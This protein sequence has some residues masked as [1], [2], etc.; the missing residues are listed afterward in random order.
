[1]LSKLRRRYGGIKSGAVVALALGILIGGVPAVAQ[2]VATTSA[3]LAKSVAQALKLSGAA[4]KRS[5]KALSI[6]KG[7][8]KQAGPQGIPG[9]QGLQGPKGDDG[10]QG[11][12]GVSGLQV[13]SGQTVED[14]SG[15]KSLTVECPAGKRVFGGGAAAKSTQGPI[16][17]AVTLSAS[18]PFVDDVNQVLPSE[19]HW[20][21]EAQEQTASGAPWHLNV[22]AICGNA[23]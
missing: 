21:A 4:S 16:A 17:G 7:V 1:M 6:A 20:R 3:N 18:G 14:G 5:A 8:E 13:V 10:V 19:T 12:P 9:P 11:P 2:P 23:S 15:T 22:Y